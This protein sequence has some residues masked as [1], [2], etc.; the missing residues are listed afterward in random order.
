MIIL[1][2]AI[3]FDQ[4]LSSLPDSLPR[5]LSSSKLLSAVFPHSRQCTQQIW[6]KIFIALAILGI[7]IMIEKLSVRM[8]RMF[9]HTPGWHTIYFITFMCISVTWWCRRQSGRRWQSRWWCCQSC[10]RSAGSFAPPICWWIL[11][12]AI[13]GKEGSHPCD[14]YTLLLGVFLSQHSPF[15][16][17]ETQLLASSLLRLRCEVSPLVVE[18]P[19]LRHA[20][21]PLGPFWPHS[22]QG[23]CQTVLAVP[24][25]LA[26]P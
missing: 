23:A 14:L 15:Y 21:S 1:K 7:C 12:C 25:L 10:W 9:I 8:Q 13:V 2:T 22:R 24:D 5:Q 18:F 17:Q 3:P 16:V 19:Q 20:K 11:R 26:S 4:F 6:N